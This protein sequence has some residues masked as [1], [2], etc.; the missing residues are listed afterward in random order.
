MEL[1]YKSLMVKQIYKRIVNL[2][3][4]LFSICECCKTGEKIYSC[5]TRKIHFFISFSI[6]CAHSEEVSPITTGT[7]QQCGLTWGGFCIFHLP[8]CLAWCW[9]AEQLAEWTRPQ[10]KCLQ[11]LTIW[12]GAICI[13]RS[14]FTKWRWDFYPLGLACAANWREVEKEIIY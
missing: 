11:E 13:T 12:T 3:C 2:F 4:N 10:L 8:K 5:R 6:H 7:D 1:H 9:T 14:V